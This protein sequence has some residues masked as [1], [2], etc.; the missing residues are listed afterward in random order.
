[1]DTEKRLRAANVPIY[2]IKQGDNLSES[3]NGQD[4][5]IKAIPGAGVRSFA[6]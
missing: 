4:S 2:I 5:N 3:L 6:G 1:M